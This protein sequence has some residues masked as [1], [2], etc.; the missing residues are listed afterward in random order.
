MEA[1]RVEGQRG[2]GGGAARDG[3]GDETLLSLLMTSY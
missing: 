1:G 2:G 3:D